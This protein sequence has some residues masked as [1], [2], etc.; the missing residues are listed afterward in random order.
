MPRL[1]EQN[2]RNWGDHPVVVI[3]SLIVAVL[4]ILGF[5]TGKTSLAD[6]IAIRE[7]TPNQSIMPTALVRNRFPTSL[8]DIPIHTP[9]VVGLHRFMIIDNYDHFVSV[10]QQPLSTSTE[11]KRLY[12]GD[13]IFCSYEMQG[14]NIDGAS[15]WLYCPDDG[16]FVFLPLLI[17]KP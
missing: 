11:I 3:V 17:P 1:R 2:W 9:T 12:T 5:L 6:Y 8:S 16:G 4:T 15:T 14:E 10:R 13:I 7:V